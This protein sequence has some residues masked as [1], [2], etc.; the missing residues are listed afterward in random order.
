MTDKS[1][2][3]GAV[4]ELQKLYHEQGRNL[5]AFEKTCLYEAIEGRFPDI[6][7]FKQ[8]V[9]KI[10]ELGT[11]WYFRD[12][13]DGYYPG[14]EANKLLSIW[15]RAKGNLQS[16]HEE[17]LRWA[18][19]RK[20]AAEREA[21]ASTRAEMVREILTN[22]FEGADE[23]VELLG[24][25][26]QEKYQNLKND[27]VRNAISA[28]LG[29]CEL[30]GEQLAAVGNCDHTALLRARAGSGKTTVITHKVDFNIRNLGFDPS[31]IMIL[32]FNKTA[33]DKVKGEV[34]KTHNQIAF[35]NALTFHSLAYRIVQPTQGLLFDIDSGSNA[36]QSQF[37]EGLLDKE[38]NPRF[39]EDLYQFFRAE[40]KQME[41]MGSLLTK[42]DYYTFRRNTTQDT[43]GGDP[44]KSTGEKWIADFLFEHDIRYVYERPWYRDKK[45]EQGNYHPDFSLAVN[46][47]IPDVV[48][49]HWGIDE[50]D[51]NQSVPEHWSKTWS[52]YRVEMDLKRAFWR[53]HNQ[54]NPH[55]PVAFLE[56]SIRDTRYGR[57]AF[58]KHLTQLLSGAG[59]TCAKLSA[60]ERIEKVVRKRVARFS[61]MC[62][63]FVQRAKKQRRTPQSLDE[64]ISTFDFS[65]EKEKIFCLIANRIYHRYAEELTEANRIDFDD[66]MALAVDRIEEESGNV[67]INPTSDSALNLNMLKWLLVDEFQDFSPLFFKLIEKLRLHNPALRLFCVGDDWQAIN[68]FAGSDLTYFKNFSRYFPDAALL[69]LQNNYRSQPNIVAQGNAFMAK[70]EGTQ[71]VPKAGLNSE[72][73]KLSYSNTMFV[74]QRRNVPLE[75]NLDRVFMTHQMSRGELVDCDKSGRMARLLKTCFQIMSQ[76]PLNATKFII[77]SRNNYLG[78]KYESMSKF[79]S[80]LKACFSQDG[81]SKF[82]NFDLQVDCMTAHR[83]K[84][85]Q[86]DVVIILNALDRKFPIIHSDTELYRLLGSSVEEVY[87]EEERLF[88]VALTRAKQSLYIVTETGRESEFLQRIDYKEFPLY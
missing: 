78:F 87:S 51:V 57:E 23:K 8:Q 14:L 65:C 74:E 4:K 83:S 49:E 68:G 53:D 34:R 82:D 64:K 28:S 80:K 5:Q 37:I 56:T 17:Y 69:S 81:P 32:A 58:E 39:R 76:H 30:S 84:G 63:Q 21:I 40:L 11:H 54:E 55:R 3:F 29:D 79:K 15:K 18:N 20:K 7:E 26:D 42:D 60:E 48:I 75:D 16:N 38:N 25:V 71:S 31:Q 85:Q 50:A 12:L 77:L 2:F 44:V 66:L 72:P 33:A 10:H 1:D 27:F 67:V 41:N 13:A 46:S 86:A 88:Y 59:V 19:A 22:D 70:T 35:D 45:G 9:S 47:K 62:L 24:N 73:V 36:K 6:P 61:S 52:E 43:L